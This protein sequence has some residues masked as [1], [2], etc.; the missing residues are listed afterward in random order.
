ME[1]EIININYSKIDSV[2]NCVDD[3]THGQ[4]L[5]FYLILSFGI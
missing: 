4:K 1:F 3:V 5:C 2:I